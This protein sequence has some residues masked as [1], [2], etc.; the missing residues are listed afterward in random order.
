MYANFFFKVIAN[1]ATNVVLSMLGT[2]EVSNQLIEM[3]CYMLKFIWMPFFL[4][5]L[6]FNCCVVCNLHVI[7]LFTSKW[8]CDIKGVIQG[9]SQ[10]MQGIVSNK[11][12]CD[13]NCIIDSVRMESYTSGVEKIWYLGEFC[14]ILLSVVTDH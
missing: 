2:K 5:D 9:T 7:D 11:L 3:L 14:R 10:D 8:L 13:S 12:G 6:I 1:T 4:I